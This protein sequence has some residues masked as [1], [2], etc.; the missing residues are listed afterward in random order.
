MQH[1][2]LITQGLD[3][4]IDGN[5]SYA[6]RYLKGQFYSQGVVVL[7]DING[8][9]GLFQTVWEKIKQFCAWIVGLFSSKKETGAATKDVGVKSI[10]KADKKTI[11]VTP[12][13]AKL[14]K[15][16]EPAPKAHAPTEEQKKSERVFMEI[17]TP[18]DLDN[19]ILGD[20]K[21]EVTLVLKTQNLENLYRNLT[22]VRRGFEEQF[23]SLM[24]NYKTAYRM[25]KELKGV[26][27]AVLHALS[28]IEPAEYERKWNRIKDVMKPLNNLPTNY[29]SIT[30]EQVT[31]L[32]ESDI[33]SICKT[34]DF[35]INNHI[36][37]TVDIEK[38]DM[39]KENLLRYFDKYLNG[40]HEEADKA[41]FGKV[42]IRA[43]RLDFDRWAMYDISDALANYKKRILDGEY[44]VRAPNV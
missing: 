8:M 39:S 7:G 2:Q 21:K 44:F 32:A 14:L 15:A 27:E 28:F 3:D 30:P 9:E 13:P 40:I 22:K 36:I 23:D 1:E 12:V 16:K 43:A 20:S 5:E 6:Y 19:F 25:F 31:R 34:I 4:L 35:V 33:T 38:Q 26:P 10:P 24:S 29:D 41:A 11:K 17:K 42:L 37:T 18:E